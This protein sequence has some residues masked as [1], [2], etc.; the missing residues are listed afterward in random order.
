MAPSDAFGR[1]PRMP[2]KKQLLIVFSSLLFVLSVTGTAGAG[3]Q[4]QRE[5]SLVAAVNAARAA[6][7][8]KPVSV[9]LSLRRAARSHS[10][11]MIQ[12]DVF[13]HAGLGSRMASS[14]ARGPFF[15]E[16]LAWGVGRSASARTIVRRWL[17]SPMHRANLLRPGFRRVGIGAPTG[18]FAGYRGATVV[19]ANFAGR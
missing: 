16:N 11:R 18:T 8:L 4:A 1:L 10:S 9:D 15:G 12:T 3:T 13:T 19:T 6:H 14:G 17:A 5:A 2:I 7:G